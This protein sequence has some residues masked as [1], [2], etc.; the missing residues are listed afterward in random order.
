M[1]APPSV[2]RIMVPDPAGVSYERHLALYGPVP[3]TRPDALLRE[4]EESGLRGRGGGWFP[5]ATKM[6]AVKDNGGRFLHRP[7][8][9][10]NAMEGE[11]VITT[12]AWLMTN[13][14]HLLL[15]GVALSTAIVGATD[16]A[17]AVHEGSPQAQSLLAAMSERPDDEV[18]PTL[19]E[20]PGRY[21]ASEESAL[22]R[23][24]AGGAG[25]PVHGVRPHN[26]GVSGRPTLVN[27]A[28]TLC[29]L[30]LIARFGA[31]WFRS[32]GDPDAPGTVLV[33]VEGAVAAPGEYEVPVGIP[34]SQIITMAGG[35]TGA[36]TTALTGGFGGSWTTL[37]TIQDLPWSP[38]ALR[39]A[40]AEIGAGLL[41]LQGGDDCGVSE[42][43]RMA[44][45]LAG[46]SAG[47]C[48][49][50]VF[51]L[52]TIADEFGRLA[53]ATTPGPPRARI[54]SVLAEV[55]RRGGCSLPDGAVR[56]L[57]TGLEIFASDVAAHET[58]HC[59]TG[60]PGSLPV[61]QPMPYPVIMPGKAFR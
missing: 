19:L 50:C 10:A 42:M 35:L 12:D 16:S 41:W 4:V 37:S 1:T 15:D 28:E 27:N 2:P 29:Q 11:P 51:G 30:A 31:G 6:A 59:L 8:V 38:E 55:P 49:V 60:S 33:S 20:F 53:D 13:A 18:L 54:D 25:R 26:H 58:G 21:V 39:A 23:A 52:S 17:I 5:T 34:V 48:G 7:F 43:A 9:L 44:A 22:A 24:V 40:G 47:Q 45:Y 14:P 61:P 32:V 57:Q 3:D 46:E 36:P 56:M